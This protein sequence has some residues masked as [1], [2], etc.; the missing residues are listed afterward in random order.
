M[1]GSSSLP[2]AWLEEPISAD[3]PQSDWQLLHQASSYPLAGDE[4]LV[5]H[6]EY[7]QAIA[8]RY[9]G[10]VQPDIIGCA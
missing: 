7:D 4:T 10:V 6:D 9:L 1:S 2:L 3:A 8:A 5:G